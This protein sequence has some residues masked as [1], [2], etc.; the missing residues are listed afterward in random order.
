[1]AKIYR[2]KDRIPVQIDDIVF[3]VSTLTYEQKEEIQM[4]LFNASRDPLAAVRASRLAIKYAVKGVRGI[5]DQ[6]GNP[7]ELSFENGVLT[8]ETIDELFNLEETTK[9][10]V[11]CS[12]LLNGIP[13]EIMNPVTKEPLRDKQQKKSREPGNSLV[14]R[15]YLGISLSA[16]YGD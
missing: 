13:R 3:L 2:L 4:I 10:A 9:L 6:D 11:V 1:M 7:Y 12:T 16:N 8:N 15:T 14:L 5:E